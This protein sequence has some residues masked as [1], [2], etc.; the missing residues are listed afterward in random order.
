MMGE[1]LSIKQRVVK[2]SMNPWK[3]QSSLIAMTSFPPPRV[4]TEE[5][6]KKIF[7]EARETYK[8]L[9]KLTRKM[10]GPFPRKEDGRK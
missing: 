9:K 3:K 4:L 2:T 10:E 7:K 6:I 5:D 8:H 1:P